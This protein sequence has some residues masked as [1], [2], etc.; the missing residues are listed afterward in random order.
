MRSWNNVLSYIKMNLGA[1]LNMIELSDNDIIEY[2]Q[3]HVLP[4]FSTYAPKRKF[5]LLQ[6]SDLV[7]NKIWKYRLN[8]DDYIINIIDV[9]IYR[10]GSR[11]ENLLDMLAKEELLSALDSIRESISWKFES[12]N[13]LIFFDD[14]IQ[15]YL[16]CIV[17]YGTVYD[18]LSEIPADLYIWFKKLALAEIKIIL[19][20]M[21]TKYQLSTPFGQVT[22]NGIELKQ[23]GMQEKEAIINQLQT[24]IPPP[25]LVK[26]F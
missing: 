25:T 21:R 11:G 7:D 3:E 16:P 6:N 14:R 19:G 23:E 4:E 18:N 10:G 1:P 20:N 9:F 15:I 2:L 17:Q 5:L 24:N 12:P 26:F 22:I 8:T 13:Y